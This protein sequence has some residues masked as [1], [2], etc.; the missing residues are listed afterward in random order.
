MFLPGKIH[1]FVKLYVFKTIHLFLS[2]NA[3][4]E[5][6]PTGLASSVLSSLYIPLIILLNINFWNYYVPSRP[7]AREPPFNNLDLTSSGWLSLVSSVTISVSNFLR[8]GQQ[9][10]GKCAQ[11]LWARSAPQPDHPTDIAPNPI[12]HL[13]TFKISSTSRRAI[14]RHHVL[15]QEC[16]LI[17]YRLVRGTIFLYDYTR[18]SWGLDSISLKCLNNMKTVYPDENNVVLDENSVERKPCI[19]RESKSLELTI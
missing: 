5:L 8:A 17:G 11:I 14:L 2:E 12:S 10:E 1:F 16:F 7:Y 6:I 4:F 13:S 19:N 15:L 3:I 18:L 9:K